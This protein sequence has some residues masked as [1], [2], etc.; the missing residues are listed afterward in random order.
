M[1]PVRLWIGFISY[2]LAAGLYIYVIYE[3]TDVYLQLAT[4]LIVI[5]FVLLSIRTYQ[6]A[7]E[8]SKNP[9]RLKDPQF[10]MDRVS[11]LG[12]G[13]IALYFILLYIPE[14]IDAILGWY[15]PIGFLAY[16]NL[17]L[18][19]FIGV[20]LLLLFYIISMAMHLPHDTFSYVS[21]ASKLGTVLYLTLFAY[22]VKLPLV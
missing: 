6:K 21:Y 8:V 20:Y 7:N 1:V 16:Y 19:N 11:K 18:G 10:L 3:K 9:N 14:T 5:G 12:W 17:F 2:V 22:P 15:L 13:F 4:S